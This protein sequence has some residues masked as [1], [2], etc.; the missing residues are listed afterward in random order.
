MI[1]LF[2]A[3]S[4]SPSCSVCVYLHYKPHSFHSPSSHDSPLI[5]FPFSFLKLVR[6]SLPGSQSWWVQIGQK[7]QAIKS[8][9]EHSHLFHFTWETHSLFDFNSNAHR[10]QTY[11]HTRLIQ[12]IQYACIHPLSLLKQPNP[13]TFQQKTKPLTNFSICLY[14]N[15]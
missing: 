2:F 6:F 12:T 14:Y 4:V 1:A 13:L 15:T 9:D 7:R 11:I 8:R 10:H 3:V 5:S